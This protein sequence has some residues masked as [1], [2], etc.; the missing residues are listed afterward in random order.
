MVMGKS[1]R[2]VIVALLFLC[3]QVYSAIHLSSHDNNEEHSDCYLCYLLDN[4]VDDYVL[5][6]ALFVPL[7]GH[8]KQVTFSS[9][10]SFYFQRIF[11]YFAQAPPVGRSKVF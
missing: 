6:I 7:S 5:T 1:I 4:D 11:Y 10:K 3:V 8:F 2:P 9:E